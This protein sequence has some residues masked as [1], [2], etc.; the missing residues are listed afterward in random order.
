M[1][2]RQILMHSPPY[3]FRTDAERP[4]PEQIRGFVPCPRQVRFVRPPQNQ[5]GLAAL[6]TG[7]AEYLHGHQEEISTVLT[8]CRPIF[9]QYG[10]PSWYQFFMDAARRL[11]PARGRLPDDLSL[12]DE[13]V[14]CSLRIPHAYRDGIREIAARNDTSAGGAVMLMIDSLLAIREL[15]TLSPSAAAARLNSL[16][17]E[18]IPPGFR[19]AR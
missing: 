19:A 7:A 10:V 12:E 11:P 2:S 13:L 1:E 17:S 8:T 6:A 5:A 14:Q 4:Y 3:E 9:V 15:A 16:L 18:L